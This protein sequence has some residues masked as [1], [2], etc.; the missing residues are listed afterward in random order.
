ML[1]IGGRWR[2]RPIAAGAHATACA[3]H[4]INSK[5]FPARLQIIILALI[6]LLGWVTSL[7]ADPLPRSILVLDPSEVR[8]PFFYRVFSELRSQVNANPN[9]PISIYVESLD[10]SR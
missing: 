9:G 7:A 1:I 8:G 6:A 5:K 10:L 4:L 3:L 2:D